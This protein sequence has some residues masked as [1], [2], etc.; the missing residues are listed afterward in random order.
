MFFHFYLAL[1]PNA[2]Q[3]TPE[4]KADIDDIISLGFD[5]NDALEAYMA[6][7]KQKELAINYLFDA[8]ESGALLCKNI[9][10]LLSLDFMSKIFVK[11]NILKRKSL[12]L[13]NKNH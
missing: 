5:K 10:I 12:K 6:C 4:E 8:R 7:D 3:V 1:P 11:P 9:Y 2:I 13:C